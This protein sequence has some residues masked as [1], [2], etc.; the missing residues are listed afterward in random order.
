MEVIRE[1]SNA[2]TS[3]AFAP[4]ITYEGPQWTQESYPFNESKPVPADQLTFTAGKAN[5]PGNTTGGFGVFNIHMH[6]WEVAPHLFYPPGTSD[7]DADW[8]TI[9][10]DSSRRQQCICYKFEL[11]ETQSRG[12]YLYHTHRHG[13]TSV[14]SWSGMFGLSLTGEENVTEAREDPSPNATLTQDL[15]TI[16]EQE[17]LELDDIDVNFVV[18]YDS[19]WNVSNVTTSD[20]QP[21]V[22]LTDFIRGERGNAPLNPYFV[23]NKYQPTIEARTGALTVF[24]IACVSSSRICAFQIIEE[25]DDP[26]SANSTIIPFDRVASD[27][28]TYLKPVHRRGNGNPLLPDVTASEAYLSMGGGMREV[29]TV[30]FPR[31]GNYTIWQRGVA[32]DDLVE[33]LLMT[34]NVTG[35]DAEVKSIEQYNLASA[36]P[37]ISEDREV[38]EF[39]GMTFE[40]KYDQEGLPFPYYGVGDI[41]GN[42]TE[43][44]E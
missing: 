23:N 39:R 4:N 43:A 21:E 20:G 9:E 12:D 18:I 33:Q 17:D 5:V 6:G 15:V 24:R 28:I 3:L 36:R 7:P 13:T 31:A 19:V 8:V 25:G 40:T 30:Q 37:H 44:C 2:T 22:F 35:P 42:N 34:V 38:V 10:P 1:D 26:L 14:L 29:I 32:F 16:A 11:S 27:G 41:N